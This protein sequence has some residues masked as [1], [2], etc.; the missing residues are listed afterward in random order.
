[1]NRPED[2]D[3]FVDYKAEYQAYVK[4][5]QIR[6]D[7]L[8]GLCPF[9]ADSHPSFSVDL[10]TGK[11]NCHAEGIG[12]NFISFYARIHNTDTDTAYKEILKKYGKYKEPEKKQHKEE[13]PK[14]YTLEEYAKDKHL[15]EEFLRDTCKAS[16][17]KD[18]DGT[19]YLKILYENEDG[20]ADAYRKRYGGKEFRWSYKSTGK[21]ILYGEWQFAKVREAGWAI[22]VEGESDTQTLWY[23]KFS[24]LGI[25]GAS[26]F[27]AKMAAKLQGLKLYI[28]KEPDKGGQTF[29]DKICKILSEEKFT[30]K[31]FTWSCG[32]F[33]VKDPSEL[34]IRDG[35]MAAEKI[36]EA[37]EKAE[38]IDIGDIA[39]AIPRMIKDAP[40]NLREPK[41]WTYSDNGICHID[42]K[43]DA[44]VTICHTPLIITRRLENI[45]TSEE[46]IEIGFK[47]NGKWKYAIYPRTT[48][49]IAKNITV[50]ADLGC[51]ITSENAKMVVKFLYAL[52][53][54][55]KDIIPLADSASRLGW[56]ADESFLPWH[57]GDIVLD[58]DPSLKSLA[59]A[60]Q[61]TGTLKGW[62]DTMQPHRDRDKFRFILASSFA[63]PLLDILK[64]R[65]FM[66]YN[67]GNSRGGKTAA[68]K[69]A[70]SVWGDPEQLMINFNA[71]M[72]ALERTAS[73]YNDLPVGVDERQLAGQKQ[74]A[75][76]TVVYMITN[77]VGRA[78]G[79]RNGG[80]QPIRRWRTIALATGEETISKDNSQTGV[81]TRTLE[82]YGT[83]FEDEKSASLMHQQTSLNCGNAGKEYMR[84]LLE[85]DRVSIIDQYTYMNE[86]IYNLA[87]GI[88]GAHIAYISMVAFVD[89]I[90]DTW[91]FKS[92]PSEEEVK[93]NSKK[94]LS[95]NNDSWERA[96]K[97]AK[98]MIQ[99]QLSLGIQDVNESATQFIVDWI[100]SNQSQFKEPCVGA[101]FGFFS[102][103]DKVCIYSTILNQILNK[104]GYSYR[105]ILQYLADERIIST[106]VKK[107]GSRDCAVV[108]KHNGK[109]SRVV[110]FDLGKF[111]E[112]LPM[113]EDE[114]DSQEV[115]DWQQAPDDTENLFGSRKTGNGQLNLSDITI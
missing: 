40:I 94:T 100:L 115:N 11:W 59:M 69:A 75:L 14:S 74:D 23:L 47:R 77:G 6:G 56:Q 4:K 109:N 114:K 90:I 73:F 112:M 83:P 8:T 50:L 79:T 102:S 55:N 92:Q 29:I 43:T 21:L 88:D 54:A 27:N 38:K 71:T 84:R 45:E 66:I 57:G 12:G 106:H 1:M 87:N 72:T 39:E 76:E 53:E 13:K 31:I 41:G 96:V 110:E 22:L 36:H 111:S 104:A 97:M 81:S 99:E 80:L 60:C 20:K 67:W 65:S 15:P 58:F 3:N 64:Q 16:T 103:N 86:E 28:H 18:R 24:A 25:P 63:A 34:Y 70:L 85:T 44:P 62:I 82:I 52:E 42:E 46:K 98:T 30:G 35:D 37:I 61:T 68:L 91:L 48:I 93:Y 51:T 2:I 26:T 17:G 89:A 95:I 5:A 108:K 49:F 9:H 101:S 32:Q 19:C 107:D 113:S 78:R 105:K 33:G 10:K 7:N